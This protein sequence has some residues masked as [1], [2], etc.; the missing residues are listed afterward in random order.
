MKKKVISFVVTLAMVLS[1]AACG[2]ATSGVDWQKQ[3]DELNEKIAT[4]NGKIEELG[5]DYAEQL[6]KIEELE[7]DN[8]EQLKK[9]E[10]L[11]K[12]NARKTDI[13]TD[14]EEDLESLLGPGLQSSEVIAEDGG[15]PYVPVYAMY[16]TRTT[17]FDKAKVKIILYFGDIGVPDY[18]YG[19]EHASAII[20]ARSGAG[21]SVGYNRHNEGIVLKT[22]DDF[23]ADEYV[24]NR[25]PSKFA[26]FKHH[27]TFTVPEEVFVGEK[28]W[29]SI[30]VQEVFFYED[31]TIGG[32]SGSVGF[33]LYYKVT[34]GTVTLST[35]W[36]ED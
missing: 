12:E 28:G 4:Q 18:Y 7:K 2:T 31:G 16:K 6:K 19:D 13:I 20:T 10:E 29:V 33:F 23:S 27:E 15:E 34:E 32:S 17:T 11:E 24:L 25:R 21:R 9:I 8:A 26:D 22:I 1:F 5:N 3:F 36:F 35:T 14:L 30:S